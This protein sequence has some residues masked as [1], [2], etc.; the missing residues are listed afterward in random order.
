MKRPLSVYNGIASEYYSER[1]ITSRNF[2]QA[3]I[4]F[5]HSHNVPFPRTG[6]VLDLGAGRGSG[7]HYLGLDPSTVIQADISHRMLTLENREPSLGRISCDAL[8]LPFAD[9]CF[10]GVCSFLCDPYL[11]SELFFSIARV[12]KPGGTFLGTVPAKLWGDAIRRVRGYPRDIARFQTI[13][14]EYFECRSLLL[15]PQDLSR[16]LTQAGFSDNTIE[17]LSLPEDAPRVSPDIT[18]AAR[19]LKM[20]VNELPIVN[21]FIA[22]I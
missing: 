13:N 10:L 18:D 20:Q 5:L 11:R 7:G 17:E 22:R 8:N 21:A 6:L 19:H 1:H 2:D 16:G 14:G 12:L 4:K 3:T 9:N 15:S